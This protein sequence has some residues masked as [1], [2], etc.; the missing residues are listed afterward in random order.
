MKCS[1]KSKT[2]AVKIMENNLFQHNKI[3]R[4]INDFKR[5]EK[6]NVLK[7][8]FTQGYCYDFAKILQRN[9]PD[10]KIV[11]LKNRRH[12]VLEYDG[13]FYD[14]TGEIVLTRD[15]VVEYDVSEEE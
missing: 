12:Y 1:I 2:R 10:S 4:I 13:K 8:T 3:L 6:N 9:T 14:I 15:D 5:F 11:W 7:R